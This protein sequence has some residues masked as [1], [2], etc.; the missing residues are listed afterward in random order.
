MLVD[1][2]NARFQKK[3]VEKLLPSSGAVSKFFRVK[4]KY[5]FNQKLYLLSLVI[6]MMWNFTVEI[7]SALHCSA[8]KSSFLFVV[9]VK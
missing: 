7:V 6:L 2:R 8:S 9:I 3:D 1:E 4:F 5:F